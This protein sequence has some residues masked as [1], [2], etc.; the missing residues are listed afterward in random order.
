[1]HIFCPKLREVVPALREVVTAL[2]E[3]VV[4]LGEAVLGYGEG[5]RRSREGVPWSREGVPRSGE[6]VHQLREAVAALGGVVPP[7]GTVDTAAGKVVPASGTLVTS[8]PACVVKSAPS[9]RRSVA[10]MPP[11]AELVFEA[12][13]LGF[14]EPQVFGA[15]FEQFLRGGLLA[16]LALEDSAKRADGVEAGGRLPHNTASIAEADGAKHDRD[17]SLRS[18]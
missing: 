10:Q 7:L 11:A 18:G 3:A 16:G 12:R 14:F 4:A 13:P 1:M 6:G 5:V 2:R 17:P 15:V 8:S 9:A